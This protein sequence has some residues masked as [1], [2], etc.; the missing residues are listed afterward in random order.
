MNSQQNNKTE[1]YAAIAA[2]AVGSRQAT[3]RRSNSLASGKRSRCSSDVNVD[4]DNQ[5]SERQEGR[6]SSVPSNIAA[7]REAEFDENIERELSDEAIPVYT[8]SV[9]SDSVEWDLLLHQEMSPLDEEHRRRQFYHA[10]MKGEIV[11][12]S[13]KRV[14]TTMDKCL[15]RFR[16]VFER[17]GLDIDSNWQG[18]IK[19]QMPA[20][21]ATW[22]RALIKESPK[23][24]W[25]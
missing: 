3:S 8:R 9:M 10:L 16:D 12:S 22:T 7:L 11:D 21:M 25:S 17:C 4:S 5:M 20:N 1:T 19:P 13:S 24:N 14:F 6:P 2:R 18:I 15:F 23:M